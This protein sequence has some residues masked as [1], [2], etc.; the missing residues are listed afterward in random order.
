MTEKNIILIG[1]M[2]CGKT[3]IGKEIADR[4][5]R[6]F[7]DI[8]YEIQCRTKMSINDIF[9]KYGEQYFRKIERNFCKIIAASSSNIISTGGGIIKDFSNISNLKINGALIYL[10]S[11][12]EKIYKNIR[13]DDSRPLLNVDNKMCII[14]K[15]LYER[16]PIYEKYADLIIDISSFKIEESAEYIINILKR[17][18]I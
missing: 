2:G 15:L 12:P 3:S 14:K 10:K 5:Q 1:F 13:Y 6:S 4:I 7:I 16:A 11:T 8:D 18:E 17:T 9:E